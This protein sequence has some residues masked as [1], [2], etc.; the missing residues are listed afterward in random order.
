MIREKNFTRISGWAQSLLKVTVIDKMKTELEIGM[1]L[2]VNG[3]FL[4]ETCLYSKWMDWVWEQKIKSQKTLN[5]HDVTHSSLSLLSSPTTHTHTHTHM[6]KLMKSL[7]LIDFFV[8]KPMK[9]WS[10][11]TH[12][13]VL[14]G[15]RLRI[16]IVKTQRK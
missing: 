7:K 6:H 14:M 4:N 13:P 3:N 5:L 2:N 16:G 10:L 11:S 9:H 12:C 15:H 8:W 1:T